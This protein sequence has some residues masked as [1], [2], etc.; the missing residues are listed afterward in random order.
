MKLKIPIKVIKNKL[1]FV[2][3]VLVDLLIPPIYMLSSLLLFLLLNEVID[4]P[5]IY[6]LLSIPLT[7]LLMYL[8][9]CISTILLV[10]K[11]KAL[12]KLELINKIRIINAYTTN[13]NIFKKIYFFI[14]PIF[15]IVLFVS[16]ALFLAT[17]PTLLLSALVG[18]FAITSSYLLIL[19]LYAYE[20][21]NTKE[22]IISSL[23]KLIKIIHDEKEYSI[24]DKKKIQNELDSIF[25]HLNTTI[26]EI[27]DESTI[28]PA[29]L[30]NIEKLL[31]RAT[32]LYKISEGNLNIRYKITH[33]LNTIL[34]LIKTTKSTSHNTFKIGNKIHS[35]TIEFYKF[36]RKEYGDLYDENDQI[37]I[38]QIK[39]ILSIPKTLKELIT[40][41]LGQPVLPIIIPIT[42]TLIQKKIPLKALPPNIYLIPIYYFHFIIPAITLMSYTYHKVLKAEQSHAISLAIYIL[43]IIL[44]LFI[45]SQT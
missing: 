4:S 29:P 14:F 22:L 38:S 23:N 32:N 8:G 18:L 25:K 3:I 2:F 13:S 35:K 44:Q 36:L 45:I 37:G 30:P 1:S 9:G 31:K 28:T 19:I 27:C 21:L 11:S 33:F 41:I 12:N 42:L 24:N 34:S 16:F 39:K 43:M 20:N 26:T 6:L 15:G 7:G 40:K 10:E 17:T 5:F